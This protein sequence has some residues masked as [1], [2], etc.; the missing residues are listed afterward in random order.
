MPHDP[1]DIP[2]FLLRGHP[3]Y[4]KAV[5]EGRRILS[6]TEPARSPDTELIDATGDRQKC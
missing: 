6:E 1:L 5:A 2:T 3:D 4:E